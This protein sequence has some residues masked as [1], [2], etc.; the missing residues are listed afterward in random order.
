LNPIKMLELKFNK[1]KWRKV[2]LGDIVFEPKETAKDIADEGFEHIVGLEH[3][4]SD[5]IH[6]RKSFSAETET[7]FTKVFRAGDVLFG[8]RRAYLKKA[9]QATFDGVCSGDITVLRAKENIDRRL[10]PFVIHNDKFFDYAIKHSAGGLSPRVKFKDL[11]NYE[12][13][14][15]PKEQQAELADLLWAMD[16][17]VEKDLVV[18]N[19]MK[20]L[21]RKITNDFFSSNNSTWK[22]QSLGDL[23]N[24]ERGG[25][26]RPIDEYFT[27]KEDGLNWIKIGDVEVGSKYIYKTKQKIKPSGLSKT[28]FVKT[29]DLL[30]SNS[31]SFGRPFILQIDG[32]I[33]DGW[34]VIRDENKNFDKEY[35][36]YFLSSEKSYDQFKKFAAGGVVNNLNSDIIK[37]MKV[38]VPPKDIQIKVKKQLSSLDNNTSLIESKL[39]S[40][41]ALQ[42][43]LINQIF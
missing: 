11:A 16:E 17:V 36:Y 43:S 13:F 4:D 35:L 9:A 29:G 33:H 22:I 7:T 2:S 30:L 28:R 6:L 14:L 32:C 39:Q 41:K 38:S 8:R 25:S 24:I 18:L 1:E 5:D 40:S 15:P 10:L 42:K 37:K 12:F 27:D 23:C 19:N 20:E 3:I 21:Q 31:M 26:P 34:L